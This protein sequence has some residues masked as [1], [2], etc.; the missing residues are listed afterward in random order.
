MYIAFVL[1][2][3]G[4]QTQ[5][6]VKHRNK[7]VNKNR[8]WLDAQFEYVGTIKYFLIS[9]PM[10]D[11]FH[12]LLAVN[13]VVYVQIRVVSPFFKHMKHS[14]LTNIQ[15]FEFPANHVE[16][17]KWQSSSAKKWFRKLWKDSLF[18]S[19]FKAIIFP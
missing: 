17:N 8:Q 6:D 10:A 15:F 2:I 12:V 11:T 13:A 18:C 7:E 5:V 1:H 3:L 16:K 9:L 19:S 4:L 14:I